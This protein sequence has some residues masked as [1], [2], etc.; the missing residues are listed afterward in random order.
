MEKRILFWH[1]LH[2]VSVDMEVYRMVNNSFSETR[3]GRRPLVD[4]RAAGEYAGLSGWTMRRKAYAGE[5][6]SLKIGSRLL[7]DLDELDRFIDEHTR[8]RLTDKSTQRS[9]SNESK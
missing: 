9:Q 5:I 8:P 1:A 7:F 3:V 6:A 4:A 2:F